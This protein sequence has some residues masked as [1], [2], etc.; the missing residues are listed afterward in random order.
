MRKIFTVIA[1]LFAVLFSILFIVATVIVLLLVNLEHTLLNAQTYKRLLVKNKVYEQLP[2]LMAEQSSSLERF[3]ADPCADNPLVCAMDGAPPELQTCLT[4]SL[5]EEAYL[6][7]GSGQR[8]PTGVELQSSQPCL[9]QYGGYAAL[10]T[11]P[12]AGSPD[13]N[14][15]SSASAGVQACARQ[16]LGGETYDTLHD[17]QRPPTKRETRQINACIR[18]ERRNARLNNPGIGGDL[19]PILNDFSPA[20][21]EELIRFLL[22]ASDLR[23]LTESTLDQVFAYLNGETGSVSISLVDIKRRLTGQSG[24]ELLL[25]LLDSLPPC[26]P[27]QLAQVN[28]GNFENGGAPAIYCAASGEALAIMLPE[29]QNR[30]AGVVSQL[31]DEA[32][33]INPAP[34][35][36]TTGTGGP[37]GDDPQTAIRTVRNWIRLSPLVPL[38]LLLLVTLFGVRSVKGWLRWWGIPLFIAGLSAL[39]IGLAA[40]PLLDW[41]WVNTIAADIP[42]VFS[43]GLGELGYVLSRSVVHELGKWVVLE[44][45]VIILPGLAA[46]IASNHIRSKLKETLRSYTP[47]ELS[48]RKEASELVSPRGKDDSGYS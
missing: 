39:S 18:Q 38:A 23:H 6:E 24:E 9:D 22:P 31:P 12:A 8:Q 14:P 5:G 43:S 45:G 20:Q 17:G 37:F 48:S 44:A 10:Q 32:V 4:D 34:A 47:P 1:K 19:M 41:A 11:G 30:L 36:G 7:I 27:E 29:M 42:A 15:L 21:W 16:A 33:L 40:G 35:S 13:D 28:A 2:A 3:L 25:F 46:I 26:T